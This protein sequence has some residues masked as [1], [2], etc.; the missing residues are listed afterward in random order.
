M[1]NRLAE[2]AQTVAR[3]IQS[4]QKK[5]GDTIIQKT[6]DIIEEKYMNENMALSQ[7]ADE[8]G[9]SMGY[10]ST[11]FKKETGVNF[12]EYLMQIRME[13]AKELLR[14]TDYRSYEIANEVGYSNAH[15]F[16]VSFKKMTG[17]S[18]SEY[19]NS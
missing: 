19:R 14:T 6:K 12:T 17:L 10:L 16:S 5:S 9:V 18:P 7:V 2:F 15:Y 3:Q 11:L 13:K 8:V 1:E 4:V